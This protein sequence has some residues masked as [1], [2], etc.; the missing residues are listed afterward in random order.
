LPDGGGGRKK[1]QKEGR[2]EREGA[3]D[4]EWRWRKGRRRE[5]IG[6]RERSRRKRKKKRKRRGRRGEG[7]RERGE[8]TEIK[9]ITSLFSWIC[10]CP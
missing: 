1:K 6:R 4:N 2:I 7:R 10:L 8:G 5:M 3:V 9:Q